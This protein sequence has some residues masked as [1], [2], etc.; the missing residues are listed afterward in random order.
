MPKFDYSMTMFNVRPKDA[1]IFRACQEWDING[2]RY[3]LESRQ[4]SV[5][6]ADDEIG[7]LLE[8]RIPEATIR[9]RKRLF[10]TV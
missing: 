2:V 3:L 5:Y 7:G 10:V 9:V 1:P 8:V 4:A 6:D